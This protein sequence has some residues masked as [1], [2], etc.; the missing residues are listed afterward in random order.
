MKR[1]HLLLGLLTCTPSNA[2]GQE[3]LLSGIYAC[4]PEEYSP[5]VL[6]EDN[7]FRV[8]IAE[9]EHFPSEC[10]PVVW[11][12]CGANYKALFSRRIAGPYIMY[13]DTKDFF[14]GDDGSYFQIN[15]DESYAFFFMLERQDGRDRY[16]RALSEQRPLA[17]LAYVLETGSCSWMAH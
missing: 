14:V 5:G 8:A 13:S 17:P 6:G 12:R 1:W 3:Y 16:Q 2:F 4:R 7:I 11:L 15:D 9:L 10:E